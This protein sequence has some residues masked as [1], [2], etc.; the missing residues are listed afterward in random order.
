[1][2]ERS[3]ELL[4]DD[5]TSCCSKILEYTTGMNFQNFENDSKTFD[6]VIR[7]FEIIGE[8]SN[9]ISE[10]EKEKFENIDWHKLR[11]MRNRLIHDYEGINPELIWDTIQNRIPELLV[12]LNK[13]KNKL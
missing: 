11:G 3:F 12:E 1:M 4:I 2:S 6:A 7:N 5:I 8:A 9:R 13:I 10:N